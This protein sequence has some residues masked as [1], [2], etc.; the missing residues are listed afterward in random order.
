V[1][2]GFENATA[3]A[4]E[5]EPALTRLDNGP[6]D[7]EH[8]SVKWVWKKELVS[9][10]AKWDEV[11]DTLCPVARSAAIV[12]D[13]WTMLVIRELFAGGARFDEIQAQTGATAQ[14]LAARLQRLEAEGMIERR[15]YSRRPLRREYLLT[16][17]GREFYPVIFA[18]RAWGETWCKSADEPL[19][20]RMTHHKCG[21]EV[22]LDGTCP[23]CHE[24]V[25]RS[26]IDAQL[27]PEWAEER[28]RRQEAYKSQV[29]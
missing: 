11:G 10:M 21:T 2:V 17:K 6:C 7:Y 18:L 26:D 1:E 14:M 19:A 20:I 25:A 27:N 8:H 4:G 15:V 29:R 12:G 3:T 23:T 13:R 24:I 16:R 5:T 28:R 9:E 22:G